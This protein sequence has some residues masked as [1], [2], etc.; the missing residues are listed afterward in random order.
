MRWVG[1]EGGREF[2]GVGGVEV[3]CALR[4]W[5]WEWEWE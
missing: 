4:E 5:E 1:R 3:W 2:A